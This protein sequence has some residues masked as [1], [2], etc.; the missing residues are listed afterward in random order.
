MYA[1][2]SLAYVPRAGEQLASLT[3]SNEALQPEQFTNYE[4]GA[5]WDVRPSLSFTS[6]VFRLDRTNIA[7]PDPVDPTRSLLV[8]GQRTKGVEIGASGMPISAWQV[9]GAY[10]YQDGVITRTL[11]ASALAGARLA[12]LPHHTFSIWNRVNFSRVWAGGLGIV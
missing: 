8:N 2:Y 1:S 6:A 9:M 10:S 3:L 5:K 7:V 11:S 12:Q 4:A